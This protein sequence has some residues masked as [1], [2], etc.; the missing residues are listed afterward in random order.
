ML[1]R[2][3][4]K[5]WLTA[6]PPPRPACGAPPHTP[7]S[8]SAQLTAHLYMTVRQVSWLTDLHSGQPSRS[9]SGSAFAACPR[10]PAH[11]D[12]IAQ[13]LNLF[14]FYPPAP[15]LDR[16]RRHRL[17]HCF[18]HCQHSPI[19]TAFSRE[20]KCFRQFGQIIQLIARYG[21][22]IQHRGRRAGHLPSRRRRCC[23][24]FCPLLRCRGS[25]RRSGA[26]CSAPHSQS[27]RAYR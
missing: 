18:Y 25:R 2:G 13:V 3:F 5:G 16:G 10:L 27:L 6:E 19:I 22:G 24:L 15:Q 14:P 1:F 7:L 23:R 12:E 4:R 21:G 9:P 20:C 17:L 11:S 8:G 26:P